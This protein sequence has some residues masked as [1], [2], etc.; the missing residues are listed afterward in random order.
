MLR[1]QIER[2]EMAQDRERAQFI[3]Q[4]GAL[5]N[6]P[7]G[8]APAE[9]KEVLH[10]VTDLESEVA[11]QRMELTETRSAL[12]NGQ[13]MLHR[14][15]EKVKARPGL[16]TRALFALPI[17]W[18]VMSGVY[19][20]GFWFAFGSTEFWRVGQVSLSALVKAFWSYW[21]F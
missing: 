16:V 12:R 5:L 20:A 3:K 8:D 14:I 6:I 9:L 7:R 18:C 17:A 11:A 19:M 13:T 15:E 21:P 10:I 2:M 1:G 4:I